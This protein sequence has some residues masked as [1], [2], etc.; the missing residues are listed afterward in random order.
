[1]SF[2]RKISYLAILCVIL[3]SCSP[4]TALPTST[5]AATPLV[6]I[7]TQAATATQMPTVELPTVT[8]QATEPAATAVSTSGAT[9]GSTTGLPDI[10]SA[11]YLD[12]RSTPAALLLSYVNAINR[13]EYIRAY[14]Y[15]IS[16]AN[17]LGTLDN[18]SN[19]YSNVASEAITLGGVSSE[20]AAGSVYYTVPVV[21]SD[22]MTDNSISKYSGC[23]VLRLPQPANYGE[24]PIQ[25]MNIDR[26]SKTLASGSASDTDLLAAACSPAD[27]PAGQTAPAAVE[28]ITDLSAQNYID[29]RSGG[30]ELV[31]SLL[32]SINRKEYVRAYSYWQDP[33]TAPGPYDAYAAG[34]NDTQSVTATFGTVN[35]DAGAGQYY[36]TVPLAMHVTTTSSAQKTYVGCYTLHISNPGFQGT[37]PF[38]P[39]GIK[40]GKFKQVDNSADITSMLTA[41]CN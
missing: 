10:S 14:S 33:S 32:N 20:G 24:P 6:L 8:S 26:G 38:E 27:Y 40:T 7:A 17:N 13:H 37:L 22:T 35:V 34:F 21:F 19:S 12:D 9:G 41:A 39:L 25:P 5:Q 28:T 11:N 18:Y 29:N 1:M 15:W 36:Y 31:S 30:I 23:Y 16:P 2:L 3:S 4:T